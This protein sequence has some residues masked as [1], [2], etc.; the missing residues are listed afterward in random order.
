MP[1]SNRTIPCPAFGSYTDRDGVRRHYR[2]TDR[3]LCIEQTYVECET[4]PNSYVEMELVRADSSFPCPIQEQALDKTPDRDDVVRGTD[5]Q[6]ARMRGVAG[7][8]IDLNTCLFEMPYLACPGCET[9]K[10]WTKKS[11]SS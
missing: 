4:C 8:P 9:R 1:S 11:P 10:R 2:S 5:L 3:V 6:R 7:A